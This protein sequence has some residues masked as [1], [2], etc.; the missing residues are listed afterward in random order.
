MYMG[1]DDPQTYYPTENGTPQGR[2]P[3]KE[4]FQ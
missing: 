4:I 1:C 2:P 3:K